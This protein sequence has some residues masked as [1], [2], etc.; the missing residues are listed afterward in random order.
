METLLIPNISNYIQEIIDN[1]LYLYPRQLIPR[2]EPDS[3]FIREYINTDGFEI[4][5][6]LS[7]EQETINTEQEPI[8]IEQEPINIEQEPIN[9]EQDTINTEQDTINTEQD[10]INTEQEPI[11]IEQDTINTEQDAINTEQEPIDTE[12][13]PIDAEQ[14]PINIEYLSKDEIL[15]KDLSKSS[16]INC[17]VINNFINIS[18]KKKYISILRDIWKT[19]G[20]QQI[21]DN[22]TFNL[23]REQIY[24]RGFTWNNDIRLSYRSRDSKLTL[25][26]IIQMTE[27]KNYGLKLNIKLNT[28]EIIYFK[29][30]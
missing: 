1:T 3:I 25:K 4:N 21:L 30:Q 22:S 16:I 9:I 19:M 24:T 2:Q 29:Q 5:Q 17:K 11:N 27:V 15:E 13:E 23:S 8:N 18:N 28:G 10:T 6:I 26:E 7:V 20:Q 14:E 12:Q